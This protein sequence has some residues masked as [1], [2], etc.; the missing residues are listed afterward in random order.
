MARMEE[1]AARMESC[2]ISI[3]QY[4]HTNTNGA[5][6]LCR[7]DSVQPDKRLDWV[8]CGQEKND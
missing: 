1:V 4:L 8:Q 2:N 7:K 3:Q 6:G 5:S